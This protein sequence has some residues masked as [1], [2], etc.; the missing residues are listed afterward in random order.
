MDLNF[1]TERAKQC[2]QQ[3]IV[4][5]QTFELSDL[6][7]R[8]EWNSFSKGDR[9]KLGKYFK[10]EVIDRRING[11]KYLGKKDNNHATYIKIEE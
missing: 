11:V 9:G 2:I 7:E 1:M 4:L 5:N 10:N 3:K 8:C 6:F